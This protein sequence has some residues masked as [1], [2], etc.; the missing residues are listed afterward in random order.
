MNGSKAAII[1]E[2]KSK[3]KVH[4]AKGQILWI[5]AESSNI[6]EVIRVISSFFYGKILQAKKKHKNAYNIL[7]CA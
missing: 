5:Y 6:N 7:E 2:S 1:G 4:S 3:Y